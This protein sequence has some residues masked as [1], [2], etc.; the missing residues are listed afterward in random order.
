[1][2]FER[3]S[4][5]LPPKK[6]NLVNKTHLRLLEILPLD[7]QTGFTGVQNAGQRQRSHGQRNIN[8]STPTGTQHNK[9]KTRTL[10]TDDG[11]QQTVSKSDRIKG[12][13]KL[14]RYSGDCRQQVYTLV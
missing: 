9:I 3:V 1:M 8:W 7:L 11:Q 6:S 14:G 12:D 10:A 2:F 5:C 4:H 13:R